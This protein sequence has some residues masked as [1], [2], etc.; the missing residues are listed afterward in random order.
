MADLHLNVK[1]IYFQ[2]YLRGEKTHEYREYNE[3]WKKRLI[4]REYSEI[5]Y[6]SGYPKSG[7][8]DKVRVIPYRGY[9]V[10]TIT[11]SHFGEAP[12]KVFAINLT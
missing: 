9:E 1:D 7:D 8:K 11:H 10:T 2:Q 3:Y 6:K 5:Y 4:G 12:I